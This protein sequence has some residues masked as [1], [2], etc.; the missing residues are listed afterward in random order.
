MWNI[1]N[2]L[3]I[4]WKKYCKDTSETD[5]YKLIFLESKIEF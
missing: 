5:F 3:I 1:H 4:G 2:K